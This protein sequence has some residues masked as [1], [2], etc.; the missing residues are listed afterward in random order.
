MAVNSA[1]RE[2]KVHNALLQLRPA[3]TLATS[4]SILRQSME[5]KRDR[6]VMLPTEACPFLEDTLFT[7]SAGV[8][9]LSSCIQNVQ[10]GRLIIN[11]DPDLICIFYRRRNT[12]AGRSKDLKTCPT[13]EAVPS[14]FTYLFW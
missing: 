2:T 8:Q 6:L 1:W 5:I 9:Y 3:C 4:E 11:A 13:E 10:I 12:H 7:H 14:N